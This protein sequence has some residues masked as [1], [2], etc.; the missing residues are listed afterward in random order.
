[1]NLVL[2][3]MEPKCPSVSGVCHTDIHSK[4]KLLTDIMCILPMCC[5]SEQSIELQANCLSLASSQLVATIQG[6]RKQI[7]LAWSGITIGKLPPHRHH[8][9]WVNLT[10]TGL[11][12]SER[13]YFG[14]AYGVSQFIVFT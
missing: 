2:G 8:N 1:M 7:C 10:R 14:Q 13:L 9:I 11:G 6:R 5:V 3:S 4:T 12:C